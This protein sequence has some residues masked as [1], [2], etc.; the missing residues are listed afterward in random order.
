MPAPS[1]MFSPL[2]M[3]TS[4]S[5]SSRSAGRRSST[6]RRPAGPKTSARKRSLS[7]GR[8]TLQA[9]ARSRRGCPSRSCS[10]RAPA[11]RRREVGDEP[12]RV[13]PLTT[14]VPTVDRRIGAELRHR[15]DERR[16]A[17][18]LDVD[19]RSEAMARDDVRRDADDRAVDGREHVGAGASRRRRAR[20]SCRRRAGTRSDVRR[21]RR[22]SRGTRVC[23]TP[24]FPWW[25]IGA[26]AIAPSAL[27][28]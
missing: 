3:Q 2:T 4:A 12:M 5:S 11:A 6:A 20:T 23:T 13:A 14:F 28:W 10:A 9:E 16:R 19:A 1:A 8:A 26:S 7:S 25:P 17:L 21:R 22:R 27:E 15:D 24:S 18:R